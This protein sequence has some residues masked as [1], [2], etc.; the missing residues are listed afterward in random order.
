MT[1]PFGVAVEA[2]NA[3]VFGFEHAPKDVR[4]VTDTRAIVPGDTFLALRGE[5][6]DGHAYVGEALAKGAVAVIIEDADAWPKSG[7]A[8]V[9]AD[10]LKAY[11]SL[12]GAART[13]FR[14][15]VLGI[16]GS[17][18][19]T[20]TKFLAAQLLALHY[21]T[22]VLTSPA[23]ENN[24]IGVSK[25][26]LNADNDRH[27]VLVVEMGA[28]H[29]GDIAALVEIARPH[30]GILT[31]VGDAHIEIMGSR[32][33]LEETKWAL[34]AAGARAVINARDIASITR[35]PGLAHRPHWF[36]AGNE[37]SE[38]PTSGRVTAIC[39][40][41]L[42]DFDID[43]ARDRD[44]RVD[45][46]I[47]GAHNRENLAAA[48]AAA[49]EFDVD[50]DAIA[51]AIPDL[52]MPEGR[53]ERMQLP[54]GVTLIYDAYNANAAGM[55]AALDAFAQ[56]EAKRRIALLGSMAELGEAASELHLRVGAHAAETQVD[57]MLVGGEF[58]GE[59][60]AGAVRAGLSSERIVPF[61][62]NAQAAQW[63]RTNARAGDA[64]LLKGSRKYH[65]EE[66]VEELRK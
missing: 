43:T 36:Y 42:I 23:N 50:L 32:E 41:R 5:R 51:A 26:L 55:M 7:T 34:F 40:D 11:M 49:L 59:L 9:V 24:E 18:G 54:S 2:T 27:D 33:R 31:N 4:V 16:T 64:V 66:I 30:I 45:I 25:L 57:V 28:R 65:L 22:R 10:T 37:R 21:G 39:N 46:R 56:E 35:A 14:G 63:V 44:V 38:I 1:L 3:T 19:K 8:L 48:I 62:T 6:F 13:R 47:P 20:T 58:A 61:A 17:A 12:A 52:A 15:R 60:S 29:F 53:Y